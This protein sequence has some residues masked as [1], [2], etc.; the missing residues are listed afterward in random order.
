MILGLPVT[1]TDEA[2]AGEEISDW[3]EEAAV[4]IEGMGLSFLWEHILHAVKVSL[5]GINKV[6]GNEAVCPP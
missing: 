1:I 3:I 2:Q 5:L 4:H 6:S